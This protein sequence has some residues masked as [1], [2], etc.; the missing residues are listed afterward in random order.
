MTRCAGSRGITAEE[1][2]ARSFRDLSDPHDADVDAPQIV[3]LLD[4][5]DQTAIRSRSDTD[6]PGAIWSGCC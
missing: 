6:T 5:H 2:C 4:G 1:I 3:E